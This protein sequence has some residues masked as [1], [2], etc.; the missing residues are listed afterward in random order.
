MSTTAS[1]HY[2]SQLR[3]A[4][5]RIWEEGDLSYIDEN[6]ADDYLL[7]ELSQEDIIGPEGF[8]EYVRMF[9]TAFPDLEGE[10]TDIIVEGDTAAARYSFRGTHEG[11]LLGVA[12]TGKSVEVTGMGFFRF[13]DGKR[14]E[15]WFYDDVLG[16]MRQLGIAQPTA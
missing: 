1:E 14:K 4:I 15:D 12:P 2:K 7:H 10:L 6:F 9:R 11:E 16:L 13:E 5:V 8:K 3:E